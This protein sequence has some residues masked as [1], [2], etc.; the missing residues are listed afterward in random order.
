MRILIH[1]C[2][3]FIHHFP[4][5]FFVQIYFNESFL[6]HDLSIKWLFL[7][8][9]NIFL[10]E[11]FFRLVKC[12]PKLPW[13]DNFRFST[14]QNEAILSLIDGFADRKKGCS[15][16]DS[17]YMAN[18]AFTVAQSYIDRIRGSFERLIRARIPL[19]RILKI[20]EHFSKFKLNLLSS[21][22]CA[23]QVVIFDGFLVRIVL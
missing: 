15:A 4:F 7:I 2:F 21:F 16:K 1:L 12:F 3:K 13:N 17:S 8:F 22:D 5:K 11:D 18:H 6:V 14:R 10:S 20:I 19:G 9:R 23:L